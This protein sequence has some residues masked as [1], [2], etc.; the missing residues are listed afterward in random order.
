MFADRYHAHV[1][2]TPREVRNAL[3]YVFHNAQ[4]HRRRPSQDLDP[5]SSARWFDGWRDR[6]V[7]ERYMN[8]LAEA[9]TWLLNV[10]WRHWGLLVPKPSG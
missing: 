4:K 9:K 10:G 2:K 1:L 3:D 8:P 7:C 5:F 6:G